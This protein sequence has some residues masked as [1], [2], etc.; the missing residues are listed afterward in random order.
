MNVIR[1]RVSTAPLAPTRTT[2]TYVDAFPATPASAVKRVLKPALD[3]HRN[4]TSIKLRVRPTRAT[5]RLQLV[6]TRFIFEY[7]IFA[8]QSSLSQTFLS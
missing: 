2:P 5:T 6:F 1:I 8:V 3:Y 4:N 7:S